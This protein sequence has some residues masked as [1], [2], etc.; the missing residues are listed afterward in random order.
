MYVH[1]RASLLGQRSRS[2]PFQGICL[3]AWLEHGQEG[4]E[5]GGRS[6]HRP[7]FARE[8]G[9]DKAISQITLPAVEAIARILG[10]DPWLLALALAGT[11]QQRSKIDA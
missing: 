5:D 11:A 9:M 4:R 10:E 8:M 3:T 1:L 7:K 2:S 6:D